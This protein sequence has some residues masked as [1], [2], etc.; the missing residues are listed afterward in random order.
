VEIS[1]SIGKNR[2]YGIFALLASMSLSWVAGYFAVIS[3]GG[4]GIRE[5][6]M[7]E[8]LN[9]IVSVQTA[10]IFPLVSRVMYLMIEALL[11]LI[12]L[13]LGM[14]YKIFSSERKVPSR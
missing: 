9:N 13:L 6:V 14:K 8:M 11:G 5:G 12:A 1:A 7:L 2:I 10:L 4:L 3:P